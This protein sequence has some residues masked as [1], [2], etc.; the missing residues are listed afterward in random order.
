MDTISR[1]AKYQRRALEDQ[2]NRTDAAAPGSASSTPMQP[3]HTPASQVQRAFARSQLATPYARG[4]HAHTRELGSQDWVLSCVH[5]SR[6]HWGIP[7]FQFSVLGR[8]QS[9]LV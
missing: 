4:L 5:A 1:V 2:P 3:R 8:H 7:A 9:I 6:V